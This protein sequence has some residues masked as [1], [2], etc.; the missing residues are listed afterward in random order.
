MSQQAFSS[1]APIV[2]KA[3]REKA[4]FEFKTIGYERI[5]PA[6]QAAEPA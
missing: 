2:L 5:R 1:A 6:F 4:V 3:A